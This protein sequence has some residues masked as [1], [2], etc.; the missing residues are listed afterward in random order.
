LV[1]EIRDLIDEFGKNSFALIAGKLEV[2][3]CRTQQLTQHD[4]FVLIHRGHSKGVGREVKENVCEQIDSL[5]AFFGLKR[6][7]STLFD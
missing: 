2:N 1:G 6:V 7:A 5:S 3:G 4:G